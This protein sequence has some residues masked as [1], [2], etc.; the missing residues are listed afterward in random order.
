MGFTWRGIYA[1]CNVR[2][3]WGDLMRALLPNTEIR[4]NLDGGKAAGCYLGTAQG[5]TYGG[6]AECGRRSCY[7]LLENLGY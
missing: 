1:V 6:K 3:F 7:I 2:I 4:I 5:S